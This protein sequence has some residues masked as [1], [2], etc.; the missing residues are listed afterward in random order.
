VR[1]AALSLLRHLASA[2][3]LLLLVAC[4]AAAPSTDADVSPTP[5]GPL[6]T[7]PA[8]ATVMPRP[9]AT[10]TP[11]P[12]AATRIEL[13]GKYTLVYRA[14]DPALMDAFTAGISTGAIRPRTAARDV[15]DGNGHAGGMYVVDLVGMDLPSNSLRTIATAF[16][17]TSQAAVTWTRILDTEVAVLSDRTQQ[18]DLFL[19]DG[20]LIVVAGVDPATTDDIAERLVIDNT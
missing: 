10:Q 8:S 2:V 20:D 12:D 4:S 6:W 7:A 16:A 17:Q 14:G 13:H 9:T 19:I 3:V 11:I 5:S 15:W 1:R 18:L